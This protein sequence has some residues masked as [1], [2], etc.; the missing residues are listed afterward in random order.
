MSMAFYGRP[1]AQETKSGFALF[2]AQHDLIPEPR[3]LYPPS[4]IRKK[5]L[6]FDKLPQAIG[7]PLR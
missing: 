3:L 1:V 6:F 2:A 7:V 5:I 4:L